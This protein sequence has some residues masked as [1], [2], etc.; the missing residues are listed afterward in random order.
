MVKQYKSEAFAAIH[1][2]ALGLS[3][4]RLVSKQTMRTFDEKRVTWR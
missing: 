1:E 4:A 2:A 3:Q